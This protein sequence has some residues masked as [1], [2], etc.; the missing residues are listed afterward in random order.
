M[1]DPKYLEKFS[2]Q[3][4]GIIDNL[5]TA[6]IIDM[7]K[8]IVK[9][10]NVSETTS[11]QAEILQNAGLVYANTIKRVSQVSGY[12]RREVERMY[13]EAGVRNLK[14]E[15][16]YYKQAGKEAI[17]LNQ[18]DGMQRILQANI[19]KTCQELD[20]LTMTTAVRSQSSFIQACNRAQMKVSTGA[21]SYDKAIADAIKEA[22]VQGTEVLYPSQHVDKLDVA[23]RRAV[24]TGVNQTAAEMNL[25]YAKDQGCDYVETT[26]HAGARTEHAVWQGKV[27]CLSG[28]DPKYENFYE[29]TGY[30]T[31][32]GLCGWNCRHNF[33]AYFPGISTPSYTQ[34][35]LDD[36]SAKSVEY[37]GKQFTEYEASQMQR[38]H[39][40]QIRET[41]RKL[42][43]YNTAISEAKDDTLKN[44]LQNRFN[45][46]SVR[47]KKQEAAIKAFCKE[48]GRRYESARVQVHAVKDSTGNIVG[49]NR[50][51]AQKAVWQNRK[52]KVNESRFTERLSD[53]NLGQKYIISH[54]S[55]Q[56]NLNKS[57]IGK[58]TMKYI[59]DHPE[60]NIELA[61]HVNNP[62]KLYGK[63]VENDI[64]IYASD[65]KT[66]EKTAEILIHEITHHRY[67]IGESQWAECVCR[68]QELKH[69]NRRNT[70]TGDELRS[71]IKEIKEL[72]PELPWR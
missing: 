29:A 16:V 11:H 59:V 39:E 60:I 23:V 62:D 3:L 10:G 13:E 34:D 50:S 49:F 26:A 12:Q 47:L 41:K 31:G 44:T 51:V 57:E 30:G 56:R 45:E 17:K 37:N 2:D 5:T 22:A 69:K 58:E 19:R 48:T 9:M 28:T 18:S 1:L 15:A 72:Y 4:L 42:A 35:M 67:N 27:F 46:E 33:H 40:R 43:G 14:N 55:I 20:N 38:G 63:Q 53:L 36:Y 24:L 68:A 71:I 65:T 54:W 61:Y 7:A 25:Q 70:L 32:P 64:R 52:T 21:F 8:R 6:I 66:I